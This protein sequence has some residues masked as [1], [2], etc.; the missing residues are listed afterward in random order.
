MTQDKLS[1]NLLDRL[2]LFLLWFQLLCFGDLFYLFLLDFQLLHCFDDFFLLL[3]LNLDF[4]INIHQKGAPSINLFDIIVIN[5]KLRKK[6]LVF[7]TRVCIL[8][9]FLNISI[10]HSLFDHT[11]KDSIV[12]IID[13]TVNLPPPKI[14]FNALIVR[15]ND[16]TTIKSWNFLHLCIEKFTP[17]EYVSC[18]EGRNNTGKY[19]IGSTR[20]KCCVFIENKRILVWLPISQKNLR[21][22]ATDIFSCRVHQI[23]GSE[24]V[25]LLEIMNRTK[26][27]KTT[28]LNKVG[29]T[30]I[31]TR[32]YV[33]G[34]DVLTY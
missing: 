32:M 33:W 27:G 4:F 21:E 2:N 10:C 18:S 24:I 11:P 15:I 23:Y 8:Q 31:L 3:L 9:Y 16:D 34:S 26:F 6:Y 17:V 7:F 28:A 25:R 20:K 29:C 5:P 1:S 14:I 19:F 30:S 12:Q 22:I 13:M